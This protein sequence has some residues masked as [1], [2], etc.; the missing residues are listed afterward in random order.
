MAQ[1][2][3]DS[4]S[5]AKSP[6]FQKLIA[7]AAVFPIPHEKARYE[8]ILVWT[9]QDTK[10]ATS[11]YLRND[12]PSMGYKYKVSDYGMPEPIAAG[13]IFAP[14]PACTEYYDLAIVAHILKARKG[15][16]N[17]I[18]RC[19]DRLIARDTNIGARLREILRNA[20]E[21]ERSTAKA[22][23]DRNIA[24][25][26]GVRFS[27]NIVTDSDGGIWLVPIHQMYEFSDWT[28]KLHKK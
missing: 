22:E 13:V 12:F 19:L 15:D 28:N 26:K 7:E 27:S 18:T 11:G 23:V 9:P 6:Q 17:L 10:Q 4:L 25:A 14:N 5:R 20:S 3:L 1:T 16:L 21:Q 24:L 2:E 8:K